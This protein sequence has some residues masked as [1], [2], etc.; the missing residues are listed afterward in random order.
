MDNMGDL[1]NPCDD[2][3]DGIE[4]CCEPSPL[5]N[6]NQQHPQN[7]H[8][9]SGFVAIGQNQDWSAYILIETEAILFLSTYT[10][11]AHKTVI[12]A[13]IPGS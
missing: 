13:R 9:E 4:R 2:Q 10:R 11:G 12:L 8:P 7:G 5:I 1:E 3:H 6:L